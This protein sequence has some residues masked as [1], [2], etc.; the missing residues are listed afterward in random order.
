M[1]KYFTVF[2]LAC[3]PMLGL[4]AWA[5]TPPLVEVSAYAEHFGGN[6]VYRYIVKNNSQFV[7][8]RI[9]V[10]RKPLEV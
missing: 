3:S 5:Q 8:G 9:S 2:L 7:I 1:K 4:Q 10:G 6:I